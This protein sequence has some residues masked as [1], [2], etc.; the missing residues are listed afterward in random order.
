MDLC[1]VST[2]PTDLKNRYIQSGYRP[3]NLGL[4]QTFKSI[5]K[6]HNETFNI[7]T[8]LLSLLYFLY[9][10]SHSDIQH[11]VAGL[12]TE[13]L[14]PVYAYFSGICLVFAASSGAHWFNTVSPI[15]HS[16]SFMI[17]YSGISF[18]GSCATIVF[19]YFN[20]QTLPPL[21]KS[22]GTAFVVVVIFA[23]VL[24]MWVCCVTRVYSSASCHVIRTSV[25]A[26]PFVLGSIP[27][28]ARFTNNLSNLMVDSANKNDSSVN[29][30]DL[31]VGYTENEVCFQYFKH[32]IYISSAAAINIMKLPECKYP[33]NFDIL[34]HSHQWFH[35]LIF[36][37][38][39]ENFWMTMDDIRKFI[40]RSALH[41]YQDQ[42]AI[43]ENVLY[44]CY[45]ILIMSLVSVL[46]WHCNATS[47]KD[48]QVKQ[49]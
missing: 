5:F 11:L 38:L 25:F 44:F 19:Y 16:V 36:M 15:W 20:Y 26:V 8:H 21:V 4:K 1:E 40:H 28:L 49:D 39:R 31:N 35:I 43:T 47:K 46:V 24:A 17:D 6:C 13:C 2:I 27:P 22:L 37:G 29:N 48:A 10:F 41:E 7:W 23:A 12:N 14:Y 3:I 45:V 33:G 9:W 42:P 18:Y 34:G 30:L 32:L